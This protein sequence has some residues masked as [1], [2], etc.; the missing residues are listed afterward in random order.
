M[1]LLG[2]QLMTLLTA[3]DATDLA[4]GAAGIAAALLALGWVRRVA[5][6]LNG[7]GKS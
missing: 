5:R 7:R 1:T 6:S 2:S 3:A 4:W